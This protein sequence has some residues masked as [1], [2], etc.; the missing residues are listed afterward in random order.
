MQPLSERQKMENAKV[1][2]LLREEKILN[3][4]IKE[5]EEAMELDAKKALA[6]EV[7]EVRG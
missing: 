5:A 3:A 2:A 6:K 7:R 1:A 4:Q